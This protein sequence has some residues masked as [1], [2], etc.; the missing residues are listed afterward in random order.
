LT[1]TNDSY[2][3]VHNP[4]DAN[5][6]LTKKAYLMSSPIILKRQ[7]HQNTANRHIELVG[8]KVSKNGWNVLKNLDKNASNTLKLN[9]ILD[10]IYNIKN[11]H[12]QSKIIEKLSIMKN[13]YISENIDDGRTTSMCINIDYNNYKNRCFH[14]YY[15]Q[16]LVSSIVYALNNLLE[17][18]FLLEILNKK[19]N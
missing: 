9:I 19:L 1:G 3:Y 6:H 15:A 2:T 4:S 16:E 8:L 12:I 10:S 14:N 7:K 17:C 11:E 18:S 5:H 13:E